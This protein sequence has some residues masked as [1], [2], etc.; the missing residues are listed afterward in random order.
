MKFS[1]ELKLISAGK[2][3]PRQL[4]VGR[5]LGNSILN[6]DNKHPVIL[7]KNLHLSTLIIADA[8]NRTLH[9]STQ[10]TL[11]YIRST[12]WIVGGRIPVRSFILKCIKCTKLR[13]I[14]AQQRMGQ[15]PSTQVVPSG[16][17]F[18]HF[19]VDYAGPFN[20]KTWS[21]WAA[22]QYKGYL[23][24]FV[25]LTTSALHLELVSDYTADTFLASYRRFTSRRGICKTL[26]SD[27]G[28]NLKGAYAELQRLF[29][30][31]F[32]ELGKFASLIANDGR[33]WSFNP[34][35]VPH[36][37]GKWEAGVK[38]V[39][40]HLRRIVADRI[41]TYEEMSTANTN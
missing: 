9:G 38:S 35:S 25:C 40:Y 4:R 18:L 26:T 33:A 30:A 14:A 22:R 23:V 29:G 15:L 16:R 36:F 27:C 13:K 1:D 34:P 8:H 6:Y 3:L 2:Q 10:S 37:G 41:L 5:R 39:K 32:K 21:G 7:P 19:G 31:T 11:A 12:S 20:L 17:A 24:L 28:T